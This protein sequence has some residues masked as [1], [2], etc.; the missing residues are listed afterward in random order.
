MARETVLWLLVACSI[1]IAGCGHAQRRDTCPA[2]QWVTTGAREGDPDLYLRT[3]GAAR[4]SVS[5]GEARARAVQEAHRRQGQFVVPIVN[6]A[7]DKVLTSD[8]IHAPQVVVD[9]IKAEL[10]I[11]VELMISEHS[12]VLDYYHDC[13]TGQTYARVGSQLRPNHL[14][15]VN[16]DKSLERATGDIAAAARSLGAAHGVFMSYG[17][18]MNLAV[19]LLEELRG[20]PFGP[21]SP[22]RD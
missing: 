5:F 1:L 6:K 16:R 22:W 7:L 12:M 4:S 9:Q 8:R 20:H 18:A 13:A 15:D 21:L 11:S 3:V 19:E 2:P 14:E 10:Q 17:K